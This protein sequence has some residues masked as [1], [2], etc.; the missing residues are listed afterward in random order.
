MIKLNYISTRGNYKKVS[1][2]EAIKTGMVP[3]GGLFVPERFPVIDAKEIEAM[4]NMSYQ[5]IAE[6][7]FSL[8]L[9]DF[10]SEEIKKCV[11]GAYNKKN[12]DTKDIA[13][14][15]K[16]D[17]KNYI[18]ELWHGPTAAFKDMALQIMP[19]FL[20]VSKEK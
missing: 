11:N 3:E 9:T 17:D 15:V 8:Y 18:L 20:T 1:S 4:E 19:Y 2:A 6:K 10:T 13:P 16:L 5:E 12:F 7:V 14:V